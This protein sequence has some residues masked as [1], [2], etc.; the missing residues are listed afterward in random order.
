MVELD[1][2][3]VDGAFLAGRILFGGILAFMASNH[4]IQWKM[5]SGYAASKKVPMPTWAVLGAGLALLLG[6]LSILSGSYVIYGVGLLSLFFVPVTFLMHNFWADKDVNMKLNNM[7]N[8]QKNLV[9]LGAAWMFL[10]VPTPWPYS[11]P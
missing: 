8:F 11:L 7:V 3:I 6:A 10:S 4:F 9:I 1:P 2:Q 5:M